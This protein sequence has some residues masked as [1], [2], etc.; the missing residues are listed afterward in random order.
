[1]GT[2]LYLQW[3][4]P[5]YSFA[6]GESAEPVLDYRGNKWYNNESNEVC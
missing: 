4:W 1:M 6:V 3:V 2:S 5:L